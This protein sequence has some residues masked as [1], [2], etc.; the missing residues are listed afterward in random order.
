MADIDTLRVKLITMRVSTREDKL[1]QRDLRK[2]I[3]KAQCRE[4]KI[5]E[6]AGYEKLD[7]M[8]GKFSNGL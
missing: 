6:C 5:V 8:K 1:A 7:K 2:E 3:C 4:R